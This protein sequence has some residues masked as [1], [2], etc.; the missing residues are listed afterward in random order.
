MRHS[1]SFHS[2]WFCIPTSF[3]RWIFIVVK[4][5]W[6][7]YIQKKSKNLLYFFK[8]KD[9]KI[10]LFIPNF[11]HNFTLMKEQSRSDVRKYSFSQRTINVGN[12]LSANCVHASSINMFKN[13]ID[14][15]LIIIMAGMAVFLRGWLP[16]GGKAQMACNYCFP[17]RT[18]F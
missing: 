7:G 4:F 16:H 11:T 18:M 2:R 1:L 10:T 5:L 17:T 15:Y 3:F 8:I 14:K 13:R 6:I 9:S 12:K